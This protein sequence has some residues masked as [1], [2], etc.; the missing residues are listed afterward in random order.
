MVQIL[1]VAASDTAYITMKWVVLSLPLNICCVLKKAQ[2]EVD[3]AV[4][5]ERN[6]DESDLTDLP[7][8]Q[9]IVKNENK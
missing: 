7:Y 2:D 3:G 9:A 1:I 5:K 8:F 6:I 4:G